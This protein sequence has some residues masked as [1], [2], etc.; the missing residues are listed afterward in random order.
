M[1]KREIKQLLRRAGLHPSKDRGQNFLMDETVIEEMVAAAGVGKNDLVLEVG[2]GLG[3]LTQALSSRAKSVFAIEL[4]HGIVK[5]LQASFLPRHPNVVLQAGDALSSES[6][7]ALRAWLAEHNADE[8]GGYKL[9][10][11]LPYQVTSRLLRHFTELHPRPS[12][13]VVMVQKEVAQRVTARPGDMSLLALSV[14][15]YS[16]PHIVKTVS[17]EAFEPRPEV[18]SAILACDLSKPDPDYASLSEEERKQFWKLARAGFSSKRKQLKNNLAAI[19]SR[20]P[21]E[22]QLLFEEFGLLPAARAQELSLSQWVRLTRA[23]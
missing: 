1:D 10:A 14:Q 8:E 9:V 11:N 23:L 2:P 4:D 21:S 22:I 6:Y 16:A 12:A 5:H 13:M 17:A 18:D 15:A 19:T 3:I 7:R 20:K